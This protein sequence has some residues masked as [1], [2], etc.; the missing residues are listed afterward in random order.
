MTRARSLSQLANSNVF[1]VDA[2]NS[3]V[4]IGSTI[5]DV[6]LDVGGD[7]YADNLTINN[8]IGVAAT[9]SGVVSYEDVTN[10]DS[11]G[12]ITARTGVRIDAGG[13]VVV[14]VTTVAAGTAAAPS[15]SP[16]GDSNT[17]IFFPSADQVAVAT[18]GVGRLFVDAS[19]NVGVGI[20]SIPNYNANL[21]TVSFNNTNGVVHDYAVNGVRTGSL[22]CQSTG[23]ELST[24]ANIPLIFATNSAERM[25]ITSAGLMG[26]G[27]NPNSDSRLHVKSGANDSNPVLRLEAATNNFLN[28]RQTGSV[29]D[30]HVTAGDP[31]SFTIGASE[32]ARI[33]SSGRLLV[34]LSTGRSNFNDSGIET[35]IQIEGAGN[36]DSAALSIIAN[37][38]TTNSDKRTGLLVLGRTRGTAI[39]SNT[40]VVQDDA[41]GMIEFKGNDGTSFH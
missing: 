1:S 21:R 16:T 3:R 26:L 25:R 19:G 27:T 38:G 2:N 9:F 31:L 35:K 5:P 8:L 28:F 10:V 37:S 22:V 30:I 14:G 15:I 39:G 6:K 20:S 36:D 17:G 29:Y 4:G 24:Q 13:I 18:N 40:A 33:D 11:V 12:I 23:F 34:G 7:L 41:V 32:R